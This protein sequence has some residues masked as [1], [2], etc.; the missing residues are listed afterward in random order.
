MVVSLKTFRGDAP[1]L[2]RCGRSYIK[3]LVLFISRFPR[4]LWTDNQITQ[5]SHQFLQTA[6]LSMF[7][8]AMPL[9]ILLVSLCM[10]S[11]SNCGPTLSKNGVS[12]NGVSTS[13]S[14][15]VVSSMMVIELN[16]L[17]RLSIPSICTELEPGYTECCYKRLTSELPSPSCEDG[18][19]RSRTR[20]HELQLLI[21]CNKITCR[22]DIL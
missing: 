7:L 19:M 9:H 1:W 18:Y 20:S 12:K 15:G 21:W 17:T 6:S 14:I 2:C 5:D 11:F 3:L 22:L 4:I 13:T 16:C 8:S 10:T